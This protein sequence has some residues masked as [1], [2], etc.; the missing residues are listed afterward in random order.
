MINELVPKKWLHKVH[1]PGDANP[2]Q[3]S[4]DFYSDIENDKD[5]HGMHKI[6][7]DRSEY[8]LTLLVAVHFS[9]NT[10][11]FWCYKEN[12]YDVPVITG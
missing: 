8:T 11:L 7:P 5:S 4:G 2:M 10:S 3:S 6:I 12:N 1:P 9:G